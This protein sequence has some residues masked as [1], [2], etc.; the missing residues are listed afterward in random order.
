[1]LLTMIP[2]LVFMDPSSLGLTHHRCCGHQEKATFSLL[3]KLEVSI[4]SCNSRFFWNGSPTDKK[5]R[6]Y[7]GI[8]HYIQFLLFEI[9]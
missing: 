6:L 5:G 8:T 2:P 1:M 7:I 9:L 3:V 4:D